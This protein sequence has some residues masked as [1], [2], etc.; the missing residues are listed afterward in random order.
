MFTVTTRAQ[1]FKQTEQEAM[2]DRADKLSG[3]VLMVL[4]LDPGDQEVS[5]ADDHKS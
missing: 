5:D 4:A 1:F 2:R 3:V